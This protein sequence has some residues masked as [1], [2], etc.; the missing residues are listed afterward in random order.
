MTLRPTPPQPITATVLPGSTL[1]L[2]MTAPTPVV[3]LQ[4]MRAAWAMGK[5]AAMG[6]QPVSGTTA[7]WAK[8]ATL[9]M[10]VMRCSPLWRRVVPSKRVPLVAAW[11]SQ[12][13]VRPVVQ[14]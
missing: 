4:P 5:S 8:Q 11:V 1:A 13:L 3:A 6:M 14:K 12:R 9:P 7:S 2:K 10:W